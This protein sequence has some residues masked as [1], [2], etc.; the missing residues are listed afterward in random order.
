MRIALVSTP[1]SGNT[2]VRLVLERALGL[3]GIAVHTPGEVPAR[4]PARCILQLHWPREPGFAALLAREGLRPLVLARHPLDVLVSILH[5]VRHEPL[6]ARWLDGA[7]AIPPVLAGAGPADSAFRD[8]ALGEGAARL[9]GVSAAWWTAPGA[10]RARY[11]ALAADPEGGFRAVVE[12]LGGD[13]SAVPAA[14]AATP[15]AELASAP[16]RHGWQGRAGLGRRLVPTGL[17]LR[18]GWRHRGVFR[19]LGYAPWPGLVSARGAAA[20][21]ARLAVPRTR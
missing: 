19:T 21:W 4:L 7:G 9:L 8:F 3:E 12:A 6:T 13:A 17:A 14:V 5:F 10:V 1:R 20:E 18:I 2:W 11:E 16:N 15:F